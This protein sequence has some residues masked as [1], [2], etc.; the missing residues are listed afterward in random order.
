MKRF[1]IQQ[2]VCVRICKHCKQN[3]NFNNK[4]HEHIREYHVRKFVISKNFDFRVFALEFAYK[5][6]KKSTII[7]SFV[8]FVLFIFFATSKSQK[9]WFSITF[10]S[11][12]ASARS[13][14]SIIIYKINSKSIK[15]AIVVCL[16]IFSSISSFDSVR[17]HQKFHIQKFYLI[18]ND[19]NRMFVEKFKSFDLQQHQNRCRFSQNFVFR[20]L[21]RSCLIFL[22]KFY[23]II[24]KLF[25][26]FD[27]KFNKMS[28]FQ[29]QNNVFSREFFLKQ[30][31]ITIYFKFA[32]NQKSLINQNLKN[33]KSKNLNQH[34]IAKSIRIIFN[35]N[36]FEKWIKLLYKMLDVFN[37]I[38]FFIFILFS[39]ICEMLCIDIILIHNYTKISK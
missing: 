36:L 32:I 35:E 20:Q 15:S 7:C 13:N 22:K 5:I 21:D 1:S 9:F 18:V 8:S 12:I 3:F 6:K 28:L 37:E 24:E 31:Q 34:I 11:I 23:L 17:K 4:F 29:S 39:F 19:L 33:S 25:E 27:E 38:S 2:I 14:L 26:M 16:F 30:S 10:E